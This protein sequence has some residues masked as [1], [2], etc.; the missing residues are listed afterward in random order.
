MEKSSLP[1][2]GSIQFWV[3]GFLGFAHACFRISPCC[4]PQDPEIAGGQVALKAEVPFKPRKE[5]A[6]KIPA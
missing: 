5:L 2:L 4:P 3:L 6:A 1:G